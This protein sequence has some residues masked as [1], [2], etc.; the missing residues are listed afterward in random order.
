[1][2]ETLSAPETAPSAGPGPELSVVVTLFQE[3]AT[4]E[5]LHRRLTTTLQAFGR[6]YE[7]LYVDDGSTDGTFASLERIHHGDLH[8]RNTFA[9]PTH[10]AV[11]HREEPR[12]DVLG[13]AGARA[14]AP[15]P[16]QPVSAVDDGALPVG[17]EL[18]AHG[19]VVVVGGEYL[20]E[21][22]VGQI[23]GRG[24][25][26]RQVSDPDPAERAVLPSHFDPC[27]DHL[28]ERR[29]DAGGLAGA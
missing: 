9:D 16:A 14:E 10:L 21:T 23:G 6:S 11:V 2:T 25:S 13:M 29:L 19:D 20:G 3:V 7:V 8:V 28:R 26:R 17:E 5:E 1:M 24:E 27:L 18:P 15:G 4:L 12:R 22:L